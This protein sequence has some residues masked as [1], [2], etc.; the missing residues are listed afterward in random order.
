[1]EIFLG[2]KKNYSILFIVLIVFTGL[3]INVLDSNLRSNHDQIEHV[4]LELYPMETPIYI[5]DRTVLQV[6]IYDK[7]GLPLEQ[8]KVT[9]SLSHLGKEEMNFSLQ[10]IE[11][12]LYE[13]EFRFNEWG[14]WEAIVHV[15]KGAQ[16]L[17]KEFSLY[18]NK[19]GNSPTKSIDS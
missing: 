7:K 2:K 14:N 16:T 15:K 6:I 4:S 11:N 9:I 13:S 17:K 18:V 8:A 10:A 1:M 12:G 19:L 5:G 3:F